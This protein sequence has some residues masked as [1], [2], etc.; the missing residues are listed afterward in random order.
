[1][2]SSSAQFVSSSSGAGTNT[3]T[4]TVGPRSASTFTQSVSDD[5][6]YSHHPQFGHVQRIIQSFKPVE[7]LKP[8]DLQDEGGLFDVRRRQSLRRTSGGGPT[9]RST[10]QGESTAD[11]STTSVSVSGD[12]APRSDDE[13]HAARTSRTSGS[14]SGSHYERS[15]AGPGIPSPGSDEVSNSFFKVGF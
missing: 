10:G 9:E 8:F 3:Q 1:M 7:P 2:P 12:R 6:L 11:W 15:E 4:S 5:L 14:G 13:G